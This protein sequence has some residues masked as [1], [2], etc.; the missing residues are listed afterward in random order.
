MGNDSPS[1]RRRKGYEAYHRGGD[2][3]AMNPYKHEWD[4]SDWHEGW[5]QAFRDDMTKKQQEER[6][7]AVRAMPIF[8]AID[9]CDASEDVKEILRRLAE[10]LEIN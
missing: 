3:F 2:P 8:C 6:R 9:D 7:E 10:K 4:R 5:E 1:K